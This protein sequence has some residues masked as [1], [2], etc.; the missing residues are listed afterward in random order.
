VVFHTLPPPWDD[1]VER[2]VRQV[3]RAVTA[4]VEARGN[5]EEAQTDVRKLDQADAITPAPSSVLLLPA[6]AAPGRRSAFELG[7]SLHADRLVEADDWEALE[8]LCRYGAR[9]PVAH[10]RLSTDA[11]GRVVLSLRKPLRDGR[12]QLAFTPAASAP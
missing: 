8:R 7:Y 1:D 3:A 11:Q 5:G 12:A 6:T 4:R 10:H 9:S 2:L